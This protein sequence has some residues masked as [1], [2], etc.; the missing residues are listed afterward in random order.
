MGGCE[1]GQRPDADAT[2]IH[3]GRP[4]LATPLIER[5]RLLDRL[6]HQRPLS[7]LRAPPAFGKTTLAAQWL[8]GRAR[9]TKIAAWLR[10]PVTDDADVFWPAALRSLVGAGL[11]I[12]AEA[13]RATPRATLDRALRQ[14]GPPVLLVID[15]LDNVT[16][17]RVDDELLQ[18]LRDAPRLR[19]LITL[20]G[21]PRLR[22]GP[23]TDLDVTTIAAGD[24]LFTSEETAR[25]AA[26]LMP[27]APAIVPETVYRECG[28]WPALTRAALLGIADGR[29]PVREADVV[30]VVDEIAEEFLQDRLSR[31]PAASEL[32]DFA[33]LTSAAEQLDRTVVEALTGDPAAESYLREWAR[34]GVLLVDRHHGE[35]VYRWPAVARRIFSTELRRRHPERVARLH[36]RLAEVY[37][38]DHPEWAIA[39]AVR[40]QDWASAVRI[41]DAAWRTLLVEHRPQLYDAITATP[42]E[43][44]RT[45]RRA[46]AMRDVMLQVPTEKMLTTN[47]LP[48]DAVALEALSRSADAPEQLETALAVLVAFRNCA[49]VED[50]RTVGLR[51]LAFARATRAAHPAAVTRLF[52][53]VLAQVGAALLAAGDR[54]GALDPYREAYRRAAEASFDY[55]A[56]DAASKL[57]FVHALDGDLRRATLWLQRYDAAPAT[58]SWLSSY[59]EP[60]VATAQLLTALD[61]LRIRDAVAAGF[62][63]APPLFPERFRGLYLYGRAL[64]ALHDGTAADLLDE[65]DEIDAEQRETATGGRNEG[66][67]LAAAKADLLLALGRGNQAR[68]VL[69]GEHREHPALRVGQA[70]FA[71]LTGDHAGA[72]RYAND[73]QWERRAGVRS[74]QELTLIHAVAAHRCGDPVTATHS[75]G[76]VADA[77]RATGAVRPLVTVPRSDLRE[78]ARAVP[79]AADL[80]AAGPVAE[81]PDVFP[82]SVPFVTLTQRERLVLAKL[83]AGLTLQQTADAL[84]VSYNTIRTQQASIYRKLGVD[85]RADAV[86]RAWQWG[87]L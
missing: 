85:A 12:P 87:L 69:F 44:L 52:P 35:P 70:R 62:R 72:L 29:P 54:G 65:L 26:A 33:A 46:L 82:E 51:V 19:L 1:V 76:R 78:M 77:A 57:A 16:D 50:A 2:V 84:V 40:A 30:S 4:R 32:L 25:L 17:P 49:S 56:R 38:R 86:A 10:A 58:S 55:I 31:E 18:L 67:L 37:L 63:A 20:H 59:F 21:G 43:H 39:H 45:S 80:L 66:A 3:S 61:R 47:V 81:Q 6:D 23:I 48:A 53:G 13:A 64:L 24:L 28:G 11:S 75:L 60:A 5:A 36:R 7:V 22:A 34:A 83:A 42:V 71:L 79:S 74:R 68:G 27:S 73:P 41:I 14:V 15:D 9:P 8:R